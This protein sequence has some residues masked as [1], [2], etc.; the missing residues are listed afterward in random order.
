M[1]S[2]KLQYFL[3][4]GTFAAVQPYVALLFKE[5][6]LDAEEIGYAIGASGWAIMLSP[7]LMTLLADTRFQP[8]K[9]VA[10][11]CVGTALSLLGVVLSES[12]WALTIFYFLHSLGVTALIPLQDGITFGYQKMQVER[13]ELPVPYSQ[14]RVW[15]TFG[16]VGLL[17]AMFYPIK[18]SGEVGW[19]MWGGILSF[20]LLFTNTFWM[21]NRGRREVAKRARGLPTGDA[22]K[23]LFGKG[24]FVFSLAMFLLLCCSAAYHTMYPV[25]LTEDLGLAKHWIG[26]VIMSGAL[27]EVFF[28]LS[29]P[30]LEKRWGVRNLML[31]GVVAT[32][33]RFALMFA[34]PNLWVAIGTQIFHGPMICAMMVI[35]PNV[36]NGLATESNRNSIQGVYTMLI[37]GTSRFVGTALSGHVGMIEQRAV[38]LLCLALAVAALGLLWV[39]FRPKGSLDL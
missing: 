8:R 23:A 17:V 12:Y 28:I 32:V 37:V 25:F 1:K 3:L 18:L 14:V 11:L 39:G 7:A 9:V 35:P 31:V 2:L 4:F 36:I 34:Y 20:C 26:I 15:G 19:A 10:G 13:G 21:P 24:M 5:R 33:A 6:G 29:L 38:Y 30:R 16:Y 22:A 27:L